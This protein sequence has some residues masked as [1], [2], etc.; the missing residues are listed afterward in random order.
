MNVQLN[1]WKHEVE[2]LWSALVLDFGQAARLVAEIAQQQD[3][4]FLRQAAAQAL[5]SLRQACLK[6][7]DRMTR[8][9]ARRRFGSVRDA[10][11]VI[12]APRFGRRRAEDAST[13]SDYY[14]RVLGLPSGRRL[15][16]PEIRDAYKRA[17]KK[18]HP[19][20]GGSGPAFRELSEARDALMNDLTSH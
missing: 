18:L 7:A 5:P 12:T 20:V 3:K 17:A 10:L 19:D 15:F 16:G 9:V 4:A 13:P 2:R 6:S 11:H 14:R 1:T 8:D